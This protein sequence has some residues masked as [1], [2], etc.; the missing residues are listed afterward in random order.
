MPAERLYSE[1]IWTVFP[2]LASPALRPMYE[3]AMT[4]RV[5]GTARAFV[6][7]L[8]VWME[9]IARPVERGI[10]VF[11]HDVTQ[12]EE[13]KNQNTALEKRLNTTLDQ[14]QDGLIFFDREWRYTYLNETA[15]SYLQR[16]AET[17]LSKVIWDEFPG[18][19]D[20][21]FGA[22][23]RRAMD[24]RLK[25]SVRAYHPNLGAWFESTVYPTE[26]GL[27]IYLRDVSSDEERRHQDEPG[28]LQPVSAP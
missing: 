9:V 19:Y 3:R 20:S 7:Q 21:E 6:Q 25:G 13:A 8:G 5:S 12:D 11:A 28:Q 1:T 14:I 2:E 24:E 15:E 27:A 16:T 26:E 23:Y 18:S 17:L 10:A 4:E 22:F